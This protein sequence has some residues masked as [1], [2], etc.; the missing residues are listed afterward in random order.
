VPARDHLPLLSTLALSLLATPAFAQAPPGGS[1]GTTMPS[2]PGADAYSIIYYLTDEDGDRSTPMGTQHINQFVNR[3]RCQCGHQLQAQVRL[4]STMGMA[5]DVTKQVQTFVGTMCGTAEM[6]PI[7]G[8]FRRCVVLA[9]QAVQQY[10]QGVTTNFHPIWLS[11]GI[12][13]SISDDRDPETAVAFGS[14]EANVTGESGVWMCAQTNT[15]AGCQM[16]EFFITGTQNNNLAKGTTGGNKFD[17]QPPLQAPEGI[18]AESGDEAVVVSW[19]IAATGDI[20]G[21]RVLCEEADTGKPPPDKGMSRP[22]LNIIPNGTIYYTKDNLCP[23]G[24]FSLFTPSPNSNMTSTDTDSDTAT[25]GDSI[26]DGTTGIT[27]DDTAGTTS[28]GGVIPRFA[29][30]TGTSGTSG[31]ST[32]GSSSDTTAG[33]TSGTTTADGSTTEAAV[34]GNLMVEGDEECDDGPKN[35]NDATCLDSCL[36]NVC[37]DAFLSPKEEC[38]LGEENADDG[39]CGTDCT[40]HVSE[41]LKDLDWDYVCSN[42]LPYNTKSVRITGLDNKKRYNFLLVTYD[43][44]GNPRPFPT[45]VTA[46]PVETY[47]LW[48][49]CHALGDVCGESGFCNVSGDG[50]P[51]LGFGGL[52]G[53]GLGLV[54]IRR[55]RNRMRTRA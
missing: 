39:L 40:L 36:L 4:K 34:C 42:H 28:T 49:Q 16:D 27:T 14:C 1:G 2:V 5:Y 32:S 21:F 15:L 10:V 26:G 35:G 30:T 18:R 53:L 55:R 22:D 29:A 54:G 45:L 7:G 25:T 3:A 48:D 51:L 13:A 50:D 52:F 33:S 12:D 31:T 11:N 8:Q 43:A 37:G 47:D 23:N 19:D 17:F 6:N 24:P 38:D 41:G 46:T 20:N 44:F 9:A